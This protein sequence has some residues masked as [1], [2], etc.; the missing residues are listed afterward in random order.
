MQRA[1]PRLAVIIP[2]LHG[3]GCERIVAE[4]LP[5]LN[6][7]F[8]LH[9]ILYHP[10]I[11]YP[12]PDNLKIYFLNSDNSPAHGIIFKIFRFI[13]RIISLASILRR[14][15][16]SVVLSFI[17]SNNVI[18][19]F[20]NILAGG[21]A[22]I[23]MAEH[24]I[25]EEFFRFNPYARRLGWLIKLLL[26]FVY[27]RADKVIVISNAMQRYVRDVLGVNRLTKVI[28]NGI[29]TG[30]FYP[31]VLNK[32]IS[33]QL[34]PR[35]I[36]PCIRLLNVGRLDDNKDQDFLIK[37]L[38]KVL[39]AVPDAR[40]FIL[41]VGPNEMRLLHLVSEL[42][43]EEKVFFL[44]W[45]T[46]V[47]EYMRLAD[48]FLLSSHHE[49]FSNVI[50][51]ALA[52]GVPVVTTRSTEVFYETFEHGRYGTI[53][54]IGDSQGYIKAVIDTL[55]QYSIDTKFR[56][57]IAKYAQSKFNLSNMKLQYI[58]TIREIVKRD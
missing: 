26:R 25:N 31:P 10:S 43:L 46:N 7:D 24:T 45:Q 15:R 21:K 55:R 33:A 13:K 57:E 27:A 28:Y 56:A 23:V 12:I 19:F 50:I 9:L 36:V 2:T 49:S 58:E 14:E 3:A 30:K 42:K 17:D 11:A 37:I 48:V 20:A 47:E 35:Y 29:D 18:V 32:E 38:P 52:C 8:G 44:G 53:V 6:A 41:G 16:F 22:K 51:E 54:P 40:L 39:E 34:D 4:M 5:D 1:K